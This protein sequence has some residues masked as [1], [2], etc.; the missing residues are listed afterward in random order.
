MSVAEALIQYRAEQSLP[1]KAV[2]GTLGI[3]EPY[4]R[5]IELGHKRLP[6]ERIKALSP[7]PLREVLVQAR[8]AEYA[9]KT[10]DLT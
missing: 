5:E 3:S 1:R 7:G 4:L 8:Q 6:D 9:Q 10:D 2:A